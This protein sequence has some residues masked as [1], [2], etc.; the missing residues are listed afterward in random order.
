MHRGERQV[1]VNGATGPKPIS[2][3]NGCSTG[4]RVNVSDKLKDLTKTRNTFYRAVIGVPVVGFDYG[5]TNAYERDLISAF[6]V[7]F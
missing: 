3:S 6:W 7:D 4:Y 5:V 1:E 2:R